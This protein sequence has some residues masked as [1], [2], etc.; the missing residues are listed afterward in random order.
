MAPLPPRNLPINTSG[1]GPV[2]PPATPRKP[3]TP[4]ASSSS[5]VPGRASRQSTPSSSSSGAA[6]VATPS[7][8][9]QVTATTDGLVSR[10]DE[11]TFHRRLRQILWDHR[12]ARSVWE[13]IADEDF[14]RTVSSLASNA[15]AI[16]EALA[17]LEA[18]TSGSAEHLRMADELG[19]L[20]RTHARLKAQ[21]MHDLEAEHDQQ[22]Q[23]QTVLARLLKQA[24][25][26]DALSHA[27]EKLLLEA[28]KARGDKFAIVD[29]LWSTWPMVSFVDYIQFLTSRY[30][31]QTGTL[32]IMADELI[33]RGTAPGDPTLSIAKEQRRRDDGAE[34]ELEE[35]PNEDNEERSSNA[36]R[37][38]KARR[39]GEHR[40]RILQVCKRLDDLR[41]ERGV[42]LADWF[43]D[44]CEVEVGRW[45]EG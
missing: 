13:D 34:G 40:E 28:I 21:V 24:S 5:K 27:A 42:W 35:A 31:V 15:S 37:N 12:A 1:S 39:R 2:A 8:P 36:D 43:E 41:D 23:Q 32:E 7:T 3:S 45:D 10:A 6:A 11:T 14:A 38:P 9:T 33:Q 44:L 20:L 29:P 16:D 19:A 30:V 17:R 4:S 18:A 25:K 22:Q 26:M